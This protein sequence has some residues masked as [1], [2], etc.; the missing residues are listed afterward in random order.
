[1]K[2][3]QIK[4]FHCNTCFQKVRG[5]IHYNLTPFSHEIAEVS[6]YVGADMDHSPDS[7]HAVTQ[8]A[9]YIR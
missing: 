4:I 3:L 9:F 7:G 6:S 8:H 5:N 1:M 2:Q